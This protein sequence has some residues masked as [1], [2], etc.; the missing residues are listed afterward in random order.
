MASTPNTESKKTY[1][2]LSN[3]FAINTNKRYIT[4]HSFRTKFKVYLI[5]LNLTMN[6]FY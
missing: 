3:L 4:L 5:Y 6:L 2:L 1:K